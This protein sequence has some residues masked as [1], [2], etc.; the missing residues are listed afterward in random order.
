MITAAQADAGLRQ[1]EYEL[2]DAG[3][4]SCVYLRPAGILTGAIAPD[5]VNTGRARPLAGGPMAFTACDVIVRAGAHVGHSVVGVAPLA[6]WART[7]DVPAAARIA[8]LLERIEEE[9]P[10]TEGGPRLMGIVN[11][12]PDSF[13]DGG[14]FL[15]AASALV[16]CEALLAAGAQVLDIGGE[17]TRPGAS[18]IAPD[19]ELARVRPVLD[20]LAQRRARLPGVALSIDTRRAATMRYALATGVDWINDVTALEGDPESLAVAA[21]SS[22]QVVLMHMQ[23]TPRTMNVEP[24]YA[25]VTLDVYDYLEARVAAC[26]AAGIPRT[27]LIVDPGMGFG[28]RGAHN[29]D[30]LRDLALFH[31]LGCRLL[32]GVSRKGLGGGLEALPPEQRLPSSLAASMHALALGVQILRVHDVAATRQVTEL[33][34]RLSA[35]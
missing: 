14:T 20:A 10:D 4:G 15:D 26:A 24:A 3:A 31:G 5:M 16:H 11:V 35:R 22:A 33:W 23:G 12:T 30:L 13:S 8:T 6:A 1:L 2:A 19:V 9:R 17:S 18:D 25:D 7:S 28:K 21:A 32:L 34:R 27:R 29:V